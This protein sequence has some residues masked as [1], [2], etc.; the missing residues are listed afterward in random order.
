MK[1][2]LSIFCDMDGVV[3]DFLP[4]AKKLLKNIVHGNEKI[5]TNYEVEA[6]VKSNKAFLL[7]NID[8]IMDLDKMSHK[9]SNNV[10]DIL[11][12]SI[13]CD[14]GLF[15]SGLKPLQDGLEI[16][17]P[18]INSMGLPVNMLTAPINQNVAYIG[19][20]AIHGKASWTKEWL[21]PR[22]QNVYITPAKMKYK[23]ATSMIAG[24]LEPHI[25][26]DD[27]ESTIK[28]WNKAGGIGIL[29]VT[30]KSEQTVECLKKY[31]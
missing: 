10:R 3:V 15:F 23:Y 25:L 13:G 16:L 14:P 1:K 29:H 9:D 17:W 6:L 31:V 27:K 2:P 7:E 20:E 4:A 26:I 5:F 8:S 12:S 22:P 24:N 18:F 30:G 11:Y 21:N 19:T 28:A